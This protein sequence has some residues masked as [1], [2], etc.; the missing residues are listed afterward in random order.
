MTP[1]PDPTPKAKVVAGGLAGSATTIVL[2]ILVNYAGV[3]L[4]AEVGAALT[5]ILSFVFAYVTS[6]T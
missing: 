5:T 1:A 3:E 6:E 2:F 4:P